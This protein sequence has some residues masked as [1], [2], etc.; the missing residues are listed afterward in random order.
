MTEVIESVSVP[1]SEAYVIGA[2]FWHV[3]AMS[4]VSDM[5]KPEHFHDARNRAA[6]RAMQTVYGR[7]QGVDVATVV[8]EIKAQ[9]MLGSEHLGEVAYRLSRMEHECF[10]KTNIVD[11]ALF[12]CQAWLNRESVLI[13]AEAL[14]HGQDHNQDGFD[15]V[16]NIAKR[17]EQAM[18]GISQRRADSYASAEADELERMDAPKKALHTTGFR[19]LDAVIGGY[20]R[21]DLVIVAARPGMGK[22]SFAVSS[23]AQAVEN[24]HPTALFSLELN[25]SKMQARLFSRFSGVPLASIVREE[26][27]TEQIRK[28]HEML[29]QKEDLPL[30]IRYDTGI[31]VEDIRA[32]A[33]RMVRKHAIGCIVIDQL[34]WIKP[35]KASNRDGE[36]GGITRALKQL[37]M[38]LDIGVVLLTQLNRSVETRGGDKIPH[39][40]DL[41]D[42]G[43]IEQDAQVVLFLYRPEY[44]GITE[45]NQGSTI[46][47]V[48]VIVAKN[49]NGPCQTVRM[50]FIPE[51]ASI[52]EQ[53]T[54]Y[55]DPR[56][57]MP[58]NDD[59]NSS[60]NEHPPF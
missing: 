27:T 39:L 5:L 40:S 33:T 13:G 41:R 7:G 4:E 23:V 15:V 17:A 21:G 59:G 53:V 56:A 30:W 3:A 58:N 48:D 57:G 6:W 14:A 16:G 37:A 20:Q 34:N 45:D 11:H 51:T 60:D 19:C 38:Q 44:Y 12:I 2:C 36:V 46:G 49:S 26:L 47:K 29:G 18:D 22:T 50:E 24:G 55:Y 25:Q 42:S 31:T 10:G 32:E 54:T 28:R 9:G 8:M 1:E 43:N 35:P 52:C